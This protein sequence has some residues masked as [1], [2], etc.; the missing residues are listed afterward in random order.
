MSVFPK[1]LNTE[2]QTAVEHGDGPL[3]IIAGAGTGKTTVVTE[4]IKYLIGKGIRPS[5]ILALTF[6]EKA[7]RE[8]EER[9]DVALPYGYS[10]LWIST[11]HSFADR[12]LRSEGM[13]IGL[14]PGFRLMT[15]AE[16]IMF[17]RKHLFAFNLKYFRPLGNPTKFI[18]AILQ[19][20]SRLKDEDVSPQQYMEWAQS[21]KSKINPSTPSTT[22]RINPLRTRSQN[23]NSK[24]EDDEE[25]EAAKYL[26][27]AKAYQ[28]YEEF[29]VKE[30]LED[31]SN[32]LSHVLQL[33]R[34]R[35]NVLASYRQQFQQ[36][37]IDEFQDTNFAQYAL[38]KLLA[39][40]Q[41]NPNL[42]MV[43][44]DNQS[45]Y[46]FRGAAIS[47]MLMFM[48]DYKS[49]KTIVLTQNYRST[50]TILDRSYALIKKND[51]D[52][53]EAKL[54][55][56]KRLTSTRGLA[57]ENIEL[58]YS[59]RVED[60][61]EEVVKQIKS[62]SFD[63]A[64]DK[65]LKIK[66]KEKIYSWKDFAILLRANNHAEP[67]VKALTRAGIPYQFLG[68]GML[69]R[70]EEIK[71][72]IAYLRLLYN[73]GDS[74]SFYRVLSMDAFALSPRDLA[75]VASFSKKI[76]LSLFEGA[77][78]IAAAH[79]PRIVCEQ[80]ERY[81]NQLPY[82]GTQAKE[83]LVTF[84]LM[85]H[86]HL[87]LIPTNTAGQIL[88]YFLEDAGLLAKYTSIKTSQDE[89]IA[90]NIAKFFDKL[91]TFEV[92][93][94]D[95]SVN[96][97]VDW[98]DM[99]MSLG[100]SP[101]AADIDWSENN[102]VNILTTHSSKGLEFPVVFLVN[103]VEGRFPT[104]ERKETLPI[105]EELIK[106]ILPT[107]DFHSEEERR[108]FYVGMTRAKD[109]LFFSA[110]NYYGEGKRERK[111][112]PFV[113]ESL[114]ANVVE[115]ATHKKEETDQLFL[116]DWRKPV[117]KEVPVEQVKRSVNY[118][119]YSQIE[120]FRFCPLHY[121]AR[122]ILRLPTPVYAAASFGQSI[123][124]TLKQYYLGLMQGEKWKLDKLLSLL[125]ALWSPV[126]Y[127]SKKHE[128]AMQEEGKKQLTA[129]YEN[130]HKHEPLP[131]AV[132]QPFIF[133]V[134]SGLKI[135]GV[136]D[137]V[138]RVD[139]KTIEIIDY[140]TSTN[141]PTQSQVDK[142]LQMTLYAMAASEVRDSLFT[143][144]PEH[145]RLT[146]YF[147]GAGEKRTTTRIK[148]QL[149]EAKKEIIEVAHEIET[150]DFACSGNQWC[151]TC[152]FKMLCNVV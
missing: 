94:E 112:S 16:A 78:I 101:L 98:I 11:F 127:E 90:L 97:V 74:I 33:F 8:M 81:K 10:T 42:T 92:E 24:I 145:I 151:K 22:L 83:M 89:K 79:D 28:A 19:H 123:H 75:A 43:G 18:S 21:Q 142:N 113:Y 108:L 124:A 6:T 32:L 104:R 2:Q 13:H 9:V 40:P 27:L 14:D 125:D 50:Q 111:L 150:S 4:R 15:E 73:F 3:L 86:R 39:P 131:T 23:Y 17:F 41:E 34:E 141:V 49:A 20:F 61:A 88:Y 126:G 35:P 138:N 65:K 135:G 91:K 64:Q 25:L 148:E 120:T 54:G 52:T 60:E 82:V 56:N 144:S 76:N 132:E 7:A 69:F 47:N 53:L 136:I 51:P 48:E 106:E 37:L 134:Q 31:F 38:I 29:K 100:E 62:Q 109:R 46:R 68:P 80:V 87:G 149:E 12:V 105:P 103:L 95:A 110:S 45:I 137:R 152:E 129:F 115:K 30:G 77:E 26:E 114:E 5:E 117:T 70:Q 128:T 121:K 147:L 1:Q 107:G 140:K 85:V 143:S 63:H 36:I 99:S 84:I 55:I 58:I 116:F 67:F 133:P 66:N 130:F 44:D 119:S 118:L 59:Q 96:V 122:Y 139:E 102:A 93:H 57:G 71:D 146:L 72:L